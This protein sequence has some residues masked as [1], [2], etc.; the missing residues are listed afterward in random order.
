M[1]VPEDP[2][3]VRPLLIGSQVPDQSGF[4]NASLE[5][6]EMDYTLLSDSPMEVARTFGVAYRED[7]ETVARLKNNGMDIIKRSG[8]DHQQLPVPAVF[9][10]NTTGEVL[11]QY[12]NPDYRTRI[13]GEILMAALRA[14]RVDS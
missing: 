14:F 11:F 3:D 9:I 13:S 7:D 6:F 8:H 12:V 2:F 4:L 1:T 5:E 10:L